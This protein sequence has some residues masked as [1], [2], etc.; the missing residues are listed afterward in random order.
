MPIEIRELR[1]TAT[2]KSQSSKKEKEPK[3]NVRELKEKILAECI[4]EVMRIMEEK[5]EP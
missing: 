2:V 1:I 4:E 3:I 5:K